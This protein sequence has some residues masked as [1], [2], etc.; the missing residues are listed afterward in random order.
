MH[1]S[2]FRRRTTLSTLSIHYM[3]G[4]G[5]A[6]AFVGADGKS[7]PVPEDLPNAHMRLF[8]V[9]QYH[10]RLADWWPH[11]LVNTLT[12]TRREPAAQAR[13]CAR[14]ASRCQCLRTCPMR[15]CGCLAA[16]TTTG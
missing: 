13:L 8:G 16:S 3:P 2:P 6:G 11:Q 4:A 9:V 1:A 10:C 14:T 12:L 7:L 5:C 15:T